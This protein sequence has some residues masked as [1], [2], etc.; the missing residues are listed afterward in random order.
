MKSQFGAGFM[1]GYK[2][3]VSDGGVIVEYKY[4][5][6]F[7]TYFG[8]SY[9]DFSGL[10]YVVG[11]DIFFTNYS[12]QPCLLLG[13]NRQFGG[14]SYTGDTIEV[15]TDYLIKGYNSYIAAIGV[16]KILFEKSDALGFMS[17]TPY[18]C[19]RY[20]Y[21]ESKLI[22]LDDYENEAREDRI[23]SRISGG[24]GGGLKVVYFLNRKRIGNSE[25]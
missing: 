2:G 3:I 5:N 16:R 21:P 17:F 19:Y 15:K 12:W 13:F 18:I 14:Y 24:I 7:D 4:S 6:R 9:T 25:Q 1:V 20:T 11:T 8:L 10:G 23:N 22:F